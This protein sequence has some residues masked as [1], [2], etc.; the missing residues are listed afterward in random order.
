VIRSFGNLH[1]SDILSAPCLFEQPKR[2]GCEALDSKRRATLPS[3]HGAERPSPPGS[4]RELMR[5]LAVYDRPV[6][7]APITGGLLFRVTVP[8]ADCQEST[9]KLPPLR[10]QKKT[11]IAPGLF[12]RLRY[13]LLVAVALGF[14]GLGSAL[15]LAARGGAA[16]SSSLASLPSPTTATVTVPPLTSSPNSTSSASGFLM[17]S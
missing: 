1:G 5:L 3:R 10:P 2:S 6:P 16:I 12:S 17:C 15:G 14:L 9:P 8:E 11:R 4:P 7:N 13:E